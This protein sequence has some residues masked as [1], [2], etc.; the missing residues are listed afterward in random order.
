MA[1]SD[2]KDKVPNNW[3]GGGGVDAHQITVTV[4]IHTTLMGGAQQ[5]QEVPSGRRT[6]LHRPATLES[7]Q[8]VHTRRAS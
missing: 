2:G 5:H 7:T 1:V 6:K 4:E 8:T 3:W